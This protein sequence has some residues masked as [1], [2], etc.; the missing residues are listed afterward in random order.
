MADDLGGDFSGL[1]RSVGDRAPN[2]GG[3]DTGTPDLLG[4]GQSGFGPTP[5]AGGWFGNERA[6][7]MGWNDMAARIAL[8]K[9]QQAR[10]AIGKAVGIGLDLA[11]SGIPGL[12]LVNNFAG[13]V[14]EGYSVGKFASRAIGR[15]GLED[16]APGGSPAPAGR[17]DS[18]GPSDSASPGRA[19]FGFGPTDHEAAGTFGAPVGPPAAATP[20]QTGRAALLA[21]ANAIARLRFGRLWSQLTPEQK[22]QVAQEV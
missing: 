9:E 6:T 12:G 8:A 5:N 18:A 16:A 13:R 20:D 3:M 21:K 15:G 10:E 7:P 14:G 2:P 19:G 17:S 11:L 22:A 4:P 1:D